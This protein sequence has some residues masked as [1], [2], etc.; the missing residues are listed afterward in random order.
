MIIKYKLVDGTTE[1]SQTEKY[2][3]SKIEDCHPA[4]LEATLYTDQGKKLH[5]LKR[6]HQKHYIKYEYKPVQQELKPEDAEPAE[7]QA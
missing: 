4:I 5:T 2:A 3:F 7:P 1:Y 6:H